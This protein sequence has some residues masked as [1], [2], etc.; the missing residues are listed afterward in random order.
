MAI[1]QTVAQVIVIVMHEI[2][3]FLVSFSQGMYFVV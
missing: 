1:S 3:M 2:G